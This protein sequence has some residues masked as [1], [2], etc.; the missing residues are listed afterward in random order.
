ML[1]RHPIV[2]RRVV[3][4]NRE[5]SL[6]GS[7]DSNNRILLHADIEMEKK[8]S[9]TLVHL[10]YDRKQQC[11]NAAD[12]INFISSIGSSPSVV[13]GDFNAYNDFVWLVKA[14]MEGKPTL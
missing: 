11:R 14:I 2:K 8:I 1:S 7:T 10:S 6:S 12:I 4:L 5:Q 9:V 13:M 3:K